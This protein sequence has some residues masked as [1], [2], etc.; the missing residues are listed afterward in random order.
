MLN[1]HQDG[2]YEY[3]FNWD[4][5]P[6]LRRYDKYRIEFEDEFYIEPYTDEEIKKIIEYEKKE[7][8]TY[9]L[10]WNAEIGR[11]LAFFYDLLSKKRVFNAMNEKKEKGKAKGITKEYC[12]MYDCLVFLQAAEMLEDNKEKYTKVKDWIKTFFYQ[13]SK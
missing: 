12:F 1:T 10:T 8:G 3:E 11:C 2:Q 4:F 9:S 5:K 13:S 7:K 6:K